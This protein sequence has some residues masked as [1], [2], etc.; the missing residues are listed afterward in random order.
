MPRNNFDTAVLGAGMAGLTCARALAERGLRV[1]VLEARNRAGGRVSTVDGVELGAEFVHGRAPE[2][3]A[4]IAECGA[5]PIGRAGTMV[6]ERHD[7]GGV[8]QDDWDDALFAPLEQLEDFANEDVSFAQWLAAS[9]VPPAERPP[10]LGYVE[11]FNAADGERIG[12]KAL[13]FQQKAED[14]IEG[15]LAWHVRGGYQRLAMY[16]AERAIALGGEVR[17]SCEARAVRWSEGS[18]HIKTSCGEV[19]A[20]RCVV[21]LPL[22]VIQRVNQT[23]GVQMHPEPVAIAQAR[24]LAMGHALR[25]TMKFRERWWERFEAANDMSFL[26]TPARQIPVWWTTLQE[27]TNLLTGWCGGPR[28]TS[29]L[30]KNHAELEAMAVSNLA[31][32]FGL[33]EASVR[34]ELISTYIHNWSADP[35]SLGAYSYV[36]AGALDAPAAMGRVE[37]ATMYFAGEHTD[38]TGHWGTVHAAIRSGLRAA[39]QVLSEE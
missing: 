7:G 11:G 21:T 18:V 19:H 6:R 36:P 25:L 3:W 27:Q 4:L 32:V 30:A 22:G 5:E 16:L 29:L 9:D 17:L 13:G 1:V 35:W 33:S 26:F 24:R 2:L 10:L 34:A 14:A 37:A 12:V 28:A 8:E 15:D 31:A 23:S 20:N 38:V 39:A